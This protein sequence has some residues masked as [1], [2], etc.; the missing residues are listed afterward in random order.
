MCR[1]KQIV[2]LHHYCH[3]AKKIFG[4]FSIPSV[5]NFSDSGFV[6]IFANDFSNEQLY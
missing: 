3:T 1:M 5:N 4:F 2:N 6:C